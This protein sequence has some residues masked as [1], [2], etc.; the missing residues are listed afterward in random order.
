MIHKDI[1]NGQDILSADED[2][3]DLSEYFLIHD[4]KR[5]FLV[6][7]PYIV[8]LPLYRKIKSMEEN[9]RIF[10]TSYQDFTPNPA[11]TDAERG[12]ELFEHSPHDLLMAIGGGSSIDVAKYIRC[13]F[14]EIPFLAVPTTAGT[15]SE[16]TGFAVIY[17][18]DEKQSLSNPACLPS[19]V[20]FD[21][22]SLLSL[23]VYQKAS[24]MMDALCHAMESCWCVNSNEESLS[25]SRE[26]MRKIFAHKDGY[27]LNR[28]ED[29]AGMLQAAN[30]AGHAINL[31]KTT[32]GHAMCY[33]LTKLYGLPHGH[34]A[35]LCVNVVFP[36]MLAHPEK[37]SDPRGLPALE[38]AYDIIAEEFGVSSPDEAASAF[39]RILGSLSLGSPDRAQIGDNDIA[40]LTGTVNPERLQNHPLKF[41]EEDFAC[42][43]KQ[44]LFGSGNTN[45]ENSD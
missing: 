40:L 37:I 4:F 14:P 36:Y 12:R 38:R 18:N 32:A 31:T 42:L 23:P 22:S 3:A 41:S 6:C 16:S 10:I 39:S 17:H 43:Y 29:N 9:G 20:L 45:H 15:G 33:H 19:A 25:L 13:S 5:I 21:P 11:D 2:Y 24:T 35:A 8:K 1:R 34:A 27:L 7:A 44:L 30:L 26:A 28:P